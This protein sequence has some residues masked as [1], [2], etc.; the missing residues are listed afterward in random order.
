MEA[1][2]AATAPAPREFRVAVIGQTGVGKSALIRA[3]MRNQPDDVERPPV[4]DITTADGGGTTKSIYKYKGDDV[5]NK[6]L[7]LYDTMGIGD[8][9]TPVHKLTSELETLMYAPASLERP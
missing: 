8:S 2:A 1:P 7:V 3:L 5:G 6:R 4:L 9:N